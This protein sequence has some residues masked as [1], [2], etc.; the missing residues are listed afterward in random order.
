MNRNS[1]VNIVAIV[2]GCGAIIVAVIS[3]YRGSPAPTLQ[4]ETQAEKHAESA[5]AFPQSEA[6]IAAGDEAAAVQEIHAF[7]QQLRL[8][9]HGGD[10]KT[11]AA[12]F[13]PQVMYGSLQ[14][15]KLLEA[16][17]REERRAVAESVPFWIEEGLSGFADYMRWPRV[18]VRHIRFIAEHDEAVVYVSHSAGEDDRCKIR[19]WLKRRNGAWRVYDFEDLDIGLRATHI[20]GSLFV[21]EMKA[22][23]WN[24]RYSELLSASPLMEDEKYDECV[25]L[26]T[27]LAGAGFPPPLESWRLFMLA[28]A[29][30]SAG[31]DEEALGHLDQAE[32][33]GLN[34]PMVPRLRATVYFDMGEY[35]KV[36]EQGGKFESMLGNDADVHRTVGEALLRLNRQSEAAAAFRKAL[37]D[38]PDSVDNLSGLCRALGT[39]GIDEIRAAL[40]AITDRG[41][42]FSRIAPWLYDNYQVGALEAI[43]AAM[44]DVDPDHPFLAFYQGISYWQ[45]RK[46]DSAAASF[47]ASLAQSPDEEERRNRLTWYRLS[48]LN[49][50]K[51][52]LAYGEAADSADARTAYLEM[53][54]WLVDEDVEDWIPMLSQLNAAH[55]SKQPNDTMLPFYR[56]YVHEANEDYEAADREY[57]RGWALELTD[58]ER[59]AYRLRLVYARYESGKAV[60][61]YNE[62]RPRDETFNQLALNCQYDKNGQTLE[63]LI[64]LHRPHSKGPE[65]LALWEALSSSFLGN[66]TKAIDILRQNREAI[67]KEKTNEWSYRDLLFRSLV[68]AR[69]FA[70][71]RAA[72][73]EVDEVDRPRYHRIILAAASGDADLT[74]RLMEEI[75]AEDYY[76]YG[77]YN[78]EDLAPLLETEPFKAFRDKHPNPMKEKPAQD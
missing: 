45:R 23:P 10:Q 7:V 68:R 13:D 44:A 16:L 1:V 30:V 77:F 32:Q 53:A 8:E 31:L 72:M 71:A 69:R 67:L 24:R 6:A 4:S 29:E 63:Q 74:I 59:S 15:Q 66:H 75:L 48:M 3:I 25:A 57:T 28:S 34:L 73:M 38:D 21:G 56:G 51:G 26:L 78:D 62:I 36:V 47:K 20:M 27:D 55:E 18:Q 70:E 17:S 11:A 2:V 64:E 54:R 33:R 40:K 5:A 43:N 41:E 42:A 35:E 60:S 58:E 61:A 22:T 9:A 19:W 65:E 39:D 50:G 49:D 14:Q 76:L 12:L 46:Y 52:V 37:S